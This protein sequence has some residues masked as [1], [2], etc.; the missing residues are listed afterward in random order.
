VGVIVVLIV[1][2]M[3]DEPDFGPDFLMSSST[4]TKIVFVANKH[5][6]AAEQIVDHVRVISAQAIV[7]ANLISRSRSKVILQ[8]RSRIANVVLVGMEK[9]AAVS[10]LTLT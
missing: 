3:W 9:E 8:V 1:I 2:R 7:N 4:P 5:L 10:K 6:D